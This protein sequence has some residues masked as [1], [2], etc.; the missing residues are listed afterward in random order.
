MRWPNGARR[1]ITA[2]GGAAAQHTLAGRCKAGWR[3]REH[4]QLGCRMGVAVWC[5]PV[6]GIFR[7]AIFVGQDRCCGQAAGNS[8]VAAGAAYQPGLPPPVVQDRAA[9]V[10][11]CCLAVCAGRG[12]GAGRAAGWINRPA[13]AVLFTG[14]AR[15]A[16]RI[17]SASPAR[18]E[19]RIE[20]ADCR[21]QRGVNA[22]IADSEGAS[23]SNQV[24]D[25]LQ[26]AF[27]SAGQR[28]LVLAG[29]VPAGGDCRAGD[30]SC[31][32]RR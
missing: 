7:L 12:R 9:G 26:S 14:S 30:R 6:R 23:G 16:K 28:C 24:A 13:A 4:N 2:T 8:V 32:A 31:C 3:G 10:A 25:A 15:V 19:D 5:A 27:T 1:L 18:R 21:D 17:C 11:A 22:M 20:A 29:A